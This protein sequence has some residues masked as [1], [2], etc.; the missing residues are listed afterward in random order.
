LHSKEI[1][2]IIT[3]YWVKMFKYGTE[4]GDLMSTIMNYLEKIGDALMSFNFLSDFLDIFLVAFIIYEAIK[5]LRGSR[6]FQVIKGIAVLVV[7][8]GLVKLLNMEASEYLMSVLIQNGL[9]ILVVLFSPELRN[10][11]E[12][13]GRRSISDFSFFNFR[14]GETIEKEVISTVNN[15]CKA[16]NDLSDT[17]TGALVVFEKNAPLQDIIKTGTVLDAQSSPELFNGLF[18]KNSALHDGAVVVRDSRIYAAGC[19]LPL[20]Q[21]N[22]LD[23]ELGTRHRAAI[24]MSEQS[25]AVVVV[26]SEETGAISVAANG[27]LTR[28]I[29]RGKLREMLLSELTPQ[30]SDGAGKKKRNFFKKNK[31]KNSGGNKDE[32]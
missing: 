7:V 1:Y 6:T 8:Y 27:V 2:D 20:T 5:L 16:A 24:G 19:I 22:S 14:N 15:F 28:D 25:D 4:S 32:N 29:T 21:S 3:I 31:N 11:L 30:N 10:I 23:S 12:K 18:F 17:K 26:V 13:F 9:I